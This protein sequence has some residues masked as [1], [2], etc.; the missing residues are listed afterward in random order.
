MRSRFAS[1]LAL[2]LSA[3]LVTGCARGPEKTPLEVE[4]I[5]A[6]GQKIGA[7]RAG[8]QAKRP[9]PT[10]AQLDT[11]KVPYVEVTLENRDLLAYL[12][13]QSVRRDGDPGEIV[14]WR[15][16]EPVSEEDEQVSESAAF[17]PNA[18]RGWVLRENV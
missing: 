9:P 13:Q 8:R 16:E 12:S 17:P 3:G 4:V 18:S 6:V 2:V 7:L 5:Q 1:A 15:T 11:V 10:R 14:V